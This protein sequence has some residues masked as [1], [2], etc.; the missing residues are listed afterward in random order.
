MVLC[1]ALAPNANA[2]RRTKTT[3][4]TGNPTQQVKVERGEVVLV[5]GN[6]LVLKIQPEEGM[7]LRVSAKIPGPSV[8][9]DGVEM[10]FNFE[11]CTSSCSSKNRHG[12]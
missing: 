5:A 4:I 12:C 6:D 9:M 2:Q 10:K 1:I 11:T 8:N 7:T 3:T